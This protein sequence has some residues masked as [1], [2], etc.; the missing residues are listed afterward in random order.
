MSINDY[1]WLSLQRAAAHLNVSKDTILRRATN[2]QDQPIKGRVR[3]K[4]LQL[5]DHTR[6]DS[7]Y[8]RP[9]LDACR[10]CAAE[11]LAEL[12]ADRDSLGRH[13]PRRVVRKL[14]RRR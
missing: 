6:Q 10:N 5:G 3:R 12:P 8:Y 7:R 2:W 1:W 9:D 13:A 14:V 4:K 11:V